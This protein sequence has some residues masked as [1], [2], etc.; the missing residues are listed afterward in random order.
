L[1]GRFEF[2]GLGESKDEIKRG[3]G[4]S[5]MRNEWTKIQ[6]SARDGVEYK[7]AN[8]MDVES[9]QPGEAEVSAI[10]DGIT[11]NDRWLRAFKVFFFSFPLF[12][13]RIRA[14]ET[15]GDEPGVEA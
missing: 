7:A 13:F 14:R 4:N 15:K 8:E 2:P 6:G 11:R 9:E 10:I 1:I 12:S 5:W 3:I